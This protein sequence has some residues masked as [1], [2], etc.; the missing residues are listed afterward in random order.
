M[1]DN[2]AEPILKLEDLK[3]S[4]TS[5]LPILS[6]INFELVQ[7]EI[8]GIMGLSGSGKSM[9]AKSILQL[10]NRNTNFNIEGTITLLSNPATNVLKSSESE[11]RLIRRERISIIFQDARN[12]F[13]P[14]R[15]CFVQIKEALLLVRKLSK[16]KADE[17]VKK[18]LHWLK[19]D[20]IEHI[21]KAY[22]HELSG[23]QLQR[24]MIAIALVRDPEILIADEATTA[25]DNLSRAGILDALLHANKELGITLLIISHDFEVIKKMCDRVSIMYKGKILESRSKIDFF[26][27]P[28]HPFSAALLKLSNCMKERL[29]VLPSLEDLL[30]LPSQSANN[31]W[32]QKEFSI[33]KHIETHKRKDR[34]LDMGDPVLR[35]NDLRKTYTNRGSLFETKYSTFSLNDLNFSL[36]RSSITG[37]AGESGSGKSS[38]GRIL[39]ALDKPD[40][41]MLEFE[42][43]VLDF[44][45]RKQIREFRKKIQL[46]F[47]DPRSALDPGMKIGEAIMEVLKLYNTGL[48]RR[49][50]EEKALDLMKEVDLEAALF[51]RFPDELS[52]GQCQRVCIARSLAV[53][54]EVLICDEILSS[55][56]LFACASIINILL[57]LLQKDNLSIVFIT[58]DLNVLRFL[59]DQ[60]YVM[61]NGSIVDQGSNKYIFSESKVGYTQM[62]MNTVL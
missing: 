9:T 22:P 21:E 52:G 14:S 24:L 32:E 41:G 48:S 46:I 15:S 2:K 20:K 35:I 10:F 8:H 25:L 61:K 51:T 34:E 7:G 42:G 62:L 49:Q 3:L 47:Q 31:E 28:E 57:K 45:N 36:I 27:S 37:I 55:L 59:A 1:P 13:N 40:A 19:L 60:I 43:E 38:L 58:H 4:S 39:T 11:K 18:V 26:R 12:A 29:N 56:D 5:G 50:I 44:E 17:E 33:S 23:G 16:V 6:G 54:P 53:R 30:L